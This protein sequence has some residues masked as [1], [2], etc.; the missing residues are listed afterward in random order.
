MKFKLKSAL[1]HN[2]NPNPTPTIVNLSHA[3]SGLTD[4]FT[5][6]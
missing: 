5:K 1:H 4:E 3:M 6:R 2:P